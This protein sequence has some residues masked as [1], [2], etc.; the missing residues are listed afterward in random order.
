MKKI[1]LIAIL[2]LLGN[3]VF[4]E[5]HAMSLQKEVSVRMGLISGKG[6][7]MYNGKDFYLG[8]TCTVIDY[9]EMIGLDLGIVSKDNDIKSA[10][11]GIAFN[12]GTIASKISGINFKLPAPLTVGVFRDINSNYYVYAGAEVILKK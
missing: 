11:G 7:A 9:K 10:G 2:T 1:I 12:V 8:T 6:V 4:S 5:T 3:G